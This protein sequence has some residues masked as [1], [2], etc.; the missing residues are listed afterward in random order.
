MA[1]NEEIL[2]PKVLIVPR[3][4]AGTPLLAGAAIGTLLMSGAKLYVAVAAGTFELVTS[5]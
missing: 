3:L 2:T 5:G 4:N 1:T